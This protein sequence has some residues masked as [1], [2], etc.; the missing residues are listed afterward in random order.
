M[1]VPER[2]RIRRMAAIIQFFARF[3]LGSRVN[4]LLRIQQER[5]HLL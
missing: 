2:Q 4:R 5:Q 1:S 3:V